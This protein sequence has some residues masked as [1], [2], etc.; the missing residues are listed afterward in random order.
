[1][2]VLVGRK[3]QSAE[4]QI[5]LLTSLPIKHTYHMS[6][7]VFNIAPDKKKQTEEAF[8]EIARLLNENKSCL[9]Q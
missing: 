8:Q 2:V 7:Q 4:P 6:S 9:N 5:C 1:M 3:A